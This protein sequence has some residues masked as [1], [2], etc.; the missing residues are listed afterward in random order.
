MV[1][2]YEMKVVEDE[3]V[4]RI[5]D[6]EEKEV[7]CAMKLN[8]ALTFQALFSAM[9]CSLADTVMPGDKTGACA[10]GMAKDPSGGGG[11]GE[12]GPASGGATV[13]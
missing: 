1:T 3:I 2:R 5:T 13:H 6:S 11:E 10:L 8:Q 12:G 7:F 4:M 9:V